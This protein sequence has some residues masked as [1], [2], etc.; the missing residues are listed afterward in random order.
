MG[1]NHRAL[2][3]AARLSVRVL[4]SEREGDTRT[5]ERAVHEDMAVLGEPARLERA[6]V[7][8][9]ELAE[10][11]PEP[12]LAR[13]VRTWAVIQRG[14]GE[15]DAVGAVEHDGAESAGSGERERGRGRA[16]EW[17][18]KVEHCGAAEEER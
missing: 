17:E 10:P 2:L 13:R 14:A 9:L 16:V 8:L 12:G 15:E 11:A 5:E 3:R 7:I 18:R 1:C 6:I 4:G